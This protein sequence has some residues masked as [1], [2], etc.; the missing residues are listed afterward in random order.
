MFHQHWQVF[1][2][3]N[4]PKTALIFATNPPNLDVSIPENGF[5]HAHISM[6][7]CAE[8]TVHTIKYFF[9]QPDL[10]NA[11]FSY[12]LDFLPQMH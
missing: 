10:Q 7:D 1:L 12:M 5:M 8:Q 6:R 2:G 3:I 9:F 4:G 11:H